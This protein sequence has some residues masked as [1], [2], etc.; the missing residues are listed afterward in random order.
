MVV[1]GGKFH[2][3]ALHIHND[4]ELGYS[5]QIGIVRLVDIHTA[6]FAGATVVDTASGIKVLQNEEAT[7]QL[8]T[9]CL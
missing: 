1:L 8:S 3:L 7:S 2:L 6:D 9:E 4:L 5:P